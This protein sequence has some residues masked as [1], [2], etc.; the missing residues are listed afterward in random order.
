MYQNASF[1]QDV[2]LAVTY[3]STLGTRSNRPC[4]RS[5][6]LRPGTKMR[7][8]EPGLPIVLTRVDTILDWASSRWAGTSFSRMAWYDMGRDGKE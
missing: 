7:I 6:S 4:R 1:P 2:R 3:N 8:A 5:T